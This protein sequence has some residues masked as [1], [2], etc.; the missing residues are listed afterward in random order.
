MYKFTYPAEWFDE[1]SLSKKDI[2]YLINKQIAYSQKLH[3]NKKYF[4]GEHEIQKRVKKAGVP[5]NRLV[6][7][8]ASDIV[9]TATSYFGGNPISYKSDNDI[10]II[11]DAFHDASMDD[12]DG[13]NIQDL[14]VYG[15]AYEYAYVKEDETQPVSKTLSPLHTFMVHDDTI[16]ENELFAVY[17]YRRKDDTDKTPTRYAATVLTK[18]YKYILN[19]LD[20]NEYQQVDETPEKHFFGDIPIIEYQNNKDAKGD[21]EGVIPLIDAYNSLMSDRLNDKEQFI[22]SILAI[23][24]AML[25]DDGEESEAMKALKEMGMLELPVGSKA[26][27]ITRTFNENEVEVLKKAIEQDIHKFSHI[28][29]LSDENFA[30]N[31]SGVAMEYKL[32]GL[33]NITKIKTRYYRKG[34]KKRLKLYSNFLQ[35]KGK[36]IDISGITATFARGLPKNLL[37]LSQ[38]VA[39]L[40]G[41]V[42]KRTLL[43]QLPFVEDIDAELKAIEKESKEASDRQQAMFGIGTNTPPPKD[44]EDDAEE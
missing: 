40:W 17:Y 28:P 23:Y 38:I 3:R 31:A 12:I 8:H 41:K 35:I 37:E 42:S 2:M 6:C 26:E 19:I 22:S 13:D 20:N 4:N 25:A 9:T 43:S 11:T 18:N 21:F 10:S 24:G 32:L 7:N 36:N 33:E 5:N 1:T 39:N 27:Y 34:V 30:G 29:C 44:G 14:S 16:E 15:L